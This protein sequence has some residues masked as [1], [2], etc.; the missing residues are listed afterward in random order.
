MRLLCLQF[1]LIPSMVLW[2]AVRASIYVLL[3]WVTERQVRRHCDKMRKK[4]TIVRIRAHKVPM[5]WEE[6]FSVRCR[7][8][9]T[10]YVLPRLVTLSQPS[11][12]LSLAVRPNLSCS[13]ESSAVT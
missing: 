1:S 12:E 2:R 4:R 6:V 11:R 3:L 5:A 9:K 7:S 13:F 10:P 8:L